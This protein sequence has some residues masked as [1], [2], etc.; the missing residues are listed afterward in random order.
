[1]KQFSLISSLAISSKVEFYFQIVL[2]ASEHNIVVAFAS[3]K[4]KK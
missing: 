3:E 1:M 2:L 4:K